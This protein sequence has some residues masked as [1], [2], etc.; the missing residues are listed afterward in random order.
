MISEP[1]IGGQQTYIGIWYLHFSGTFLCVQ[2]LHGVSRLHFCFLRWHSVQES[3]P[4]FLL[5]ELRLDSATGFWDPVFILSF[6]ACKFCWI[7]DG[8][9]I[10]EEAGTTFIFYCRDIT[11]GINIYIDSWRTVDCKSSL[12][13]E[14]N[15]V[16]SLTVSC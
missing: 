7:S 8:F 9:G 5:L 14:N 12:R 3:K 1:L 4:R 2:S 10:F 11:N 13:N 6:K 16:E 15:D